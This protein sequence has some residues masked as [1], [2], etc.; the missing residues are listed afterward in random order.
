[1]MTFYINDLECFKSVKKNCFVCEYSNI[2]LLRG[3]FFVNNSYENLFLRYFVLI[4]IR[5]NS[6]FCDTKF[7]NHFANFIAR[8]KFSKKLRNC[9]EI[10]YCKILYPPKFEQCGI[11]SDSFE[12]LSSWL[13][14]N[15][16]GPGFN[17]KSV[18]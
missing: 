3:L 6:K 11:Y 10:S 15:K 5:V 1:M 9:Y 16:A 13:D 7:R 14:R 18:K 2:F 17:S 4:R 12:N 8:T